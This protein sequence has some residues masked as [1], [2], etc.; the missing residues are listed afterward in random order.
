MSCASELQASELEE[1][2]SRAMPHPGRKLDVPDM[3][4]M[5]QP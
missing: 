5:Q 3:T 4:D 1:G 2:R